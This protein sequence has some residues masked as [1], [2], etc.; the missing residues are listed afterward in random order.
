MRAW[1]FFF[2]GIVCLLGCGA[3]MSPGDD[4]GAPRGIALEAPG[5]ASPAPATWIGGAPSQTVIFAGDDAQIS[6][7]IWIDAPAEAPRGP[8]APLALSLVVDTSGSMAGDKIE[9]ARL[10]ATSLLESLAAGDIVSMYSFS[11]G[12]T[13]IAPPTEVE[14]SAM[15]D[16][17][18]QTRHFEAMGST[19]LYDGLRAGERTAGA[20]PRT[21]AVRRVIVI[22]DGQANVGPSSPQEL[23][24]VAA[25]GTEAGVQ[26]SAIGVGLDYDEQTLGALAV[27]S[28]GR[29]H[30]LERPSQMASILD[31]EVRLL[32]ATAATGALLEIQ[33]AE[34]VRV[35]G[36]ELVDAR[37]VDGALRVGLGT[38]YAGQHRELLI[39]I[40]V[41]AAVV[42]DRELLTARLFYRPRWDLPERRVQ[43]ISLRATASEDREAAAKSTE[44]RVRAMLARHEAAE[45]ERRAAALL[46]E[47]RNHE[48]AAVLDQAQT[49]LSRAAGEVPI[50]AE[51][52][53]LSAQAAQIG[54]VKDKASKATTRQAQ[55]AA[56]KEGYGY[57]FSDEGLSAPIQRPS[58]RP[59]K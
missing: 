26:V 24:D 29:L 31:Q 1:G 40:Q 59:K 16:L 51:Q 32:S 57:S 45:A 3:G 52:E 39:R 37:E 33:P 9:H 38:L 18:A 22:S 20:A 46:N 50:E 58:V 41:R 56:A 13:E 14:P 44:P 47:G 21:H 15:G 4:L 7:G 54:R 28:S 8:R 11:D 55:Q 43:A 19:N 42:G 36:A 53:L 23:G 2:T 49:D 6:V 12:V 35:L 34:G 5:P 27:R 17:I 30:H 10:A 25:Q 48:A